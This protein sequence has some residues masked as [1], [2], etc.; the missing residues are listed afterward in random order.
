[1]ADQNRP[2]H[3]S[4]PQNDGDW[5]CGCPLFKDGRFRINSVERSGNYAAVSPTR[6][7]V[8]KNHRCLRAPGLV[9]TCSASS[10]SAARL[11]GVARAIL[12]CTESENVAI[13]RG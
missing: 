9:W 12:T 6:R 3:V 5:R 10:A 4:K 7:L 1:M 2:T 8:R 13:H 11:A